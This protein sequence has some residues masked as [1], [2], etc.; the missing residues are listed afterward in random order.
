MKDM[1]RRCEYTNRVYLERDRKIGT[2]TT[3]ELTM[4]TGDKSTILRQAST[5]VRDHNWS[6]IET[7]ATIAWLDVVVWTEVE[8]GSSPCRIVLIC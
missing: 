2:P 3:R 1:R 6:K 5:C 4:Q 8:L 7:A